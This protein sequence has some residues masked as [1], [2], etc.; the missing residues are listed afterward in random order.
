[1]SK[2]YVSEIHDEYMHTM[3]TVQLH[4]HAWCVKHCPTYKHDHSVLS[5]HVWE[6][7]IVLISWLI[8]TGRALNIENDFLHLGEDSTMMMKNTAIMPNCHLIMSFILIFRRIL[9]FRF[10]MFTVCSMCCILWWRN[11]RLI[12]RLVATKY[13]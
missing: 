13:L 11:P 2:S 5:N 9:S 7:V 6:F 4:R 3:H 12:T 8:N 10:G 1:M